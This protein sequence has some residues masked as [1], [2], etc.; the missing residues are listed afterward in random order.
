MNSGGEKGSNGNSIS[1]INSN[2]NSPRGERV[3]GAF[4]E[5]DFPINSTTNRPTILKQPSSIVGKSNTWLVLVLSI[6]YQILFAFK[7][8]NVQYSVH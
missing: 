7:M 1:I 3:G 5:G 2:N 4:I 6:F 8:L